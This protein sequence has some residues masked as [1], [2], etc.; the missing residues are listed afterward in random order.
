MRIFMGMPND[1]VAMSNE[2]P[3]PND[4]LVLGCRSSVGHWG[5]AIGHSY[6]GFVAGSPPLFS[7]H[8]LR[9]CCSFAA[10]RPARR[11][12]RRLGHFSLNHLIVSSAVMPLGRNV[13]PTA[14]ALSLLVRCTSVLPSLGIHRGSSIHGP[15][16]CSSRNASSTHVKRASLVVA[17]LQP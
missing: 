3:S 4:Q 6:D 2:V 17:A 9:A 12:S 7:C 15:T 10:L 5:L 1:Q 16:P 13:R 8:A 11:F 14:T